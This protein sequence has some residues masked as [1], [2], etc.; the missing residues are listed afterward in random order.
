MTNVL[1]NVTL[2]IYMGL[3]KEFGVHAFN[4]D[5]LLT[6]AGVLGNVFMAVKAFSF[7]LLAM[8]RSLPT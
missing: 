2:Y 6:N 5:A 4:N 1:L 7:L 3:Y 8:T